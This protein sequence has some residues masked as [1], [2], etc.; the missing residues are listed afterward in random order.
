MNTT[1]ET[2]SPGSLDRATIDQLRS[3]AEQ[4][5]PALFAEILS[6]LRDD[7][8]KYLAAMHMAVTQNN[9][10][11]LGR[12]AHALKGAGL[13]TGALVLAGLSARLESTAGAGSL[14]EAPALLAQ[15]ESEIQR[16][17]ADIDLE[18]A[19]IS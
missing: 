7:V 12:S 9:A 16:V 4:T 8:L 2:K 3:L 5:T 14:A 11:A 19:G 1:P 13:N 10:V 18:L 6:T 17:R 15:L